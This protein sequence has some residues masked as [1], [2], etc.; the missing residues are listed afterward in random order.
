MPLF[1]SRPASGTLLARGAPPVHAAVAGLASRVDVAR[2][3]V[4]P[5]P[6]APPRKGGGGGGMGTDTKH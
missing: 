3:A 4:L 5:L 2:A 1:T 6:V